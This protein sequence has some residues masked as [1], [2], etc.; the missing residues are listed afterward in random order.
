MG[1]CAGLVDRWSY[2]QILVKS[3]LF[4]TF[5]CK[6]YRLLIILQLQCP[7]LQPASVSRAV[8]LGISFTLFL[9]PA[10]PLRCRNSSTC[11]KL[12]DPSIDFSIP[13]QSKSWVIKS[14]NLHQRLPNHLTMQPT[15]PKDL[16]V[17]Q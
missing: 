16:S 12:T 3:Y 6:C 14:N 8:K 7:F 13:L 2:N 4:I 11:N 1:K 15:F 17:M 9:Q 5:N 10:S